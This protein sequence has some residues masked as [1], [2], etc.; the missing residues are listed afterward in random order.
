MW[1]IPAG[2]TVTLADIEGP[3]RITH[4]WMTQPCHYRSVL[5]KITWDD[6]EAPSVLVPLGDFLGL[7]HTIVNSYQS[8]LFS[9][10]TVRARFEDCGGVSHEDAQHLGLVGPAGRASGGIG[11]ISSDVTLLAP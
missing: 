4:I 3:G 6:A 1:Q 7:G 2:K 11:M 10:S 9:A 8:F 5:L